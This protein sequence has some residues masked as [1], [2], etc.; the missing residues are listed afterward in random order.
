MTRW[1]CPVAALLFL[2]AA[3]AAAQSFWPRGGGPYIGVDAL[4]GTPS[5]VGDVFHAAF[6]GVSLRYVAS[7]NLEFS[8]DYAFMDIGYYYPET[9][10]GPWRGPLRW[11][12]MPEGFGPTGLG[13]IFY[14]TV[15]FIAPQAWYVA[16]LERYGAPIAIRV[17]A[18][19]AISLIVPNEAARF[20][21]GLAEAFEEFRSSFKAYLGLSL[22]L[23]LEYRPW[24]FARIGIEYLFLVDSLAGLAGDIGSYGMDYFKRAG[25]VVVF[26]G[27]RL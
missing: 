19:P 26:T 14:H 21:P 23:G 4:V 12:S 25:N 20:Y 18:G 7:P 1:K 9:G 15:H 10:D 13:W 2:A 24:R 8:L 17:G 3:S 11:S 6:P 16:P 27:I 5:A 22:R